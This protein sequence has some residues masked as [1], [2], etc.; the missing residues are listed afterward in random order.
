MQNDYIAPP[1]PPKKKGKKLYTYISIE[2]R[3]RLS[4][5]PI[6]SRYYLLLPYYQ[7]RSTMLLFYVGEGLAIYFR[8]A[9]LKNF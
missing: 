4:P 9:H 1:P 2:F 3:A 6:G 7:P 5:F 8:L